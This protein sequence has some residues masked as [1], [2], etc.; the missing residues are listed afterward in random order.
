LIDQGTLASKLGTFS[1]Q[2]Q[3]DKKTCIYDLIKYADIKPVDIRNQIIDCLVSIN[4]W[5][6]PNQRLDEVGL[7]NTVMVIMNEYDSIPLPAILTAM[8]NG[9]KGH[10]SKISRSL[11][12]HTI[13]GWIELYNSSQVYEERIKQLRENNQNDKQNELDKM[14]H[15]DMAELMK[16][17]LERSKNKPRQYEPSQRQLDL[18]KQGVLLYSDEELKKSIVDWTKR[19][20]TQHIKILQEEQLS[21][22]AK[23]TIK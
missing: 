9:I 13:I 11:D 5:M 4:M 7:K 22:K 19:Q 2:D 14:Y 16:A 17:A 3:L 18:F 8:S 1:L 21:R 15:S 10:Y 12:T 6:A 23:K 20:R